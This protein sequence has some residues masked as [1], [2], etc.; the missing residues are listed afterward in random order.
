MT[1]TKLPGMVINKIDKKS[2]YD[3]LVENG[4]IGEN[5]LCLVEDEDNISPG[6]GTDISLGITSASVGDIIKVKSVD[7]NGKPTG[8]E[9]AGIGETW[10]LLYQTTLTEAVAQVS[11][12]L[13][14]APCRKVGAIIETP[15]VEA[16]TNYSYFNCET[17][18][19]APGGHTAF[20]F[21]PKAIPRKEKYHEVF[22]GE[23]VKIGEYNYANVTCI[24]GNE[25]NFPWDGTNNT[26]PGHDTTMCGVFKKTIDAYGNPLGDKIISVSMTTYATFPVGTNITFFGVRA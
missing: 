11:Y 14:D 26:N 1:E 5:D 4:E 20:S 9:T 7:E 18:M 12:S 19:S 21:S 17:N 2:T 8:W 16:D 6:S 22:W 15:A 13:L 10:E 25:F 24:H 3:S 23:I